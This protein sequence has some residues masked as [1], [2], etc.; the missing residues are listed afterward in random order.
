MMIKDYRGKDRK[1][2]YP[3]E[4][5]VWGFLFADCLNKCR[6]IYCDVLSKADESAKAPSA[7]CQQLF[8]NYPAIV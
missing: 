3:N 4:F 6:S 7:M 8:S 5:L 2:S 1:K